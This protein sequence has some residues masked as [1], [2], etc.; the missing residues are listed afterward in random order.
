M[1]NQDDFSFTA[2]I[3]EDSDVL[4]QLLGDLLL[5]LYPDWKI[6]EAEN[7]MCGLHLAQT[8]Q[9]DLIITDF[10]MPIMNG[11][12]MALELRR[13]PRTSEI[14]LLLS[15]SS[16]ADHPQLI[17][18][19]HLCQATLTKP[20]TMKALEYTLKNLM[21]LRSSPLKTPIHHWASANFPNYAHPHGHLMLGR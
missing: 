2:L 14:P 18:L 10:H 3:V 8:I 19:R 4:R 16:D 1:N 15:S 13:N 21:T 11:Y 6:V 12:E 5:F 9:P 17:Q 7:G 20:Y